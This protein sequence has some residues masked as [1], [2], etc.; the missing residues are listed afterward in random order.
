[1]FCISPQFLLFSVVC[2]GVLAKSCAQVNPTT[3]YTAKDNHFLLS[4]AVRQ[5]VAFIDRHNTKSHTTG[6]VSKSKYR[7]RYALFSNRRLP[8]P[9]TIAYAPMSLVLLLIHLSGESL[10]C[11]ATTSCP[12]K[13][14]PHTHTYDEH[15]TGP[16]HQAKQQT[17]T[18]ISVPKMINQSTIVYS[19]TSP[20]RYYLTLTIPPVITS[21]CTCTHTTT[22][23]CY[24][25]WD[26]HNKCHT[27]L[28]TNDFCR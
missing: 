10:G 4:L 22:C 1:M 20:M 24:T 17:S 23:T 6:R 19:L 15:T 25:I 3:N 27:D 7:N 21:T 8:K 16:T 2:F 11:V 5:L 13:P 28:I 18:M 9:I 14:T 26:P 12:S